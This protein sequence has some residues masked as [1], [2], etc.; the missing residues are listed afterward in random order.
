MASIKGESTE[1]LAEDKMMSVEEDEK[2]SARRQ[3]QRQLLCN[4][5]QL[6]TR[7]LP[8]LTVI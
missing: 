8:P 4:G 3:H 7:G 5:E 6:H 1:E 2:N